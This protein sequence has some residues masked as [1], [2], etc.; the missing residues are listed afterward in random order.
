MP[1]NQIENYPR[2]LNPKYVISTHNTTLNCQ[3]QRWEFIKERLTEKRK[4]TRLRPRKKKDSRK[5]RRKKTRFRP[6]KNER[7]EDLDQKKERKKQ[8]RG[9]TSQ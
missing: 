3:N 9:L 7:K 8:E 5:K 2:E 4:K 1:C 6:R